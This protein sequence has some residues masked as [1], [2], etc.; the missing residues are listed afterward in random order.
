MEGEVP[1]RIDASNPRPSGD[2]LTH[3][4]SIIERQ[5]KRNT[6]RDPELIES[7]V[8]ACLVF[9]EGVAGVKA[10]FDPA[11][12]FAARVLAKAY[13]IPKKERAYSHWIELF[14]AEA[15]RREGCVETHGVSD[16]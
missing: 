12:H 4:A 16:S 8:V 1:R 7:D 14:D 9:D 13:P 6:R 2:P 3:A 15:H 10:S 5:R 11:T